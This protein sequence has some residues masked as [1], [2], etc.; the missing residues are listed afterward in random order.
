MLN[1]VTNVLKING[2]QAEVDEVKKA[3]STNKDG[4]ERAIDFNKIIPMPGTMNITS[5]TSVDFMLATLMFTEKGDDSKLRA[6][7]NYPWVK[8]EELD[9]PEKLAE[10]LTE[11][12]SDALGEAKIALKNLEEYGTKDWYDWSIQNWGTKWN[13]YDTSEEGDTIIFD[14]AWS[15]P[16]PVIQALSEM[17][18][19]VKFELSYADEDFGYN[20]GKVT[21]LNG[22][23][24]EVNI[25]KGGTKKALKIAAEIKLDSS[26]C[27]D[28]L[29][30]FSDSEDEDYIASMLDITLEDT[31]PKDLMEAVDSISYI[32]LPF[33]EALKEKFIELEAYELIPSIEQKMTEVN[34]ED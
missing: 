4:E 34:A 16:A 25:P 2:T 3:I 6:M 22:A 21:Y 17:F 24:I 11:Q 31:T 27:E 18:P 12:H 13:A 9:T 15:T 20:C 29:E 7:M 26:C 19:K 14:T 1:H 5:G 23:E 30:R 8:A 10:Y 33:L 32:S 28:F